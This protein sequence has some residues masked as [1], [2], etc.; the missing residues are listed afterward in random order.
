MTLTADV[1][2]PWRC[3]W[4]VPIPST[5]RLSLADAVAALRR[6]P[7]VEINWRFADAGGWHVTLAFLGATPAATVAPL[8][9]RVVGAVADLEPFEVTAGGLGG[10]PSRRRARVLWYG[11]S[12]PERRLRELA[13]LVQSAAGLEDGTPFRPHVTLARARQ[14]QGTDAGELLAAEVPVGS[15]SVR[16]VTLFRSHLGRGPARYEVLAEVPLGVR[17]GEPV[18]AGAPR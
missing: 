7:Q 10:F 14:R 16:G 9:E 1:E 18:A 3:F 12:D 2:R 11:L 6:D 17:L 15:V 13:R 8:V 5:L 4:A